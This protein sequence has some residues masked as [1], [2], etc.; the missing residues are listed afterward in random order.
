MFDKIFSCQVF[1]KKLECK[2]FTD[3]HARQV[4][5]GTPVIK[6]RLQIMVKSLIGNITLVDDFHQL[7]VR[8]KAEIGVFTR[9]SCGLAMSYFF[10]GNKWKTESTHA[11]GQQY[12]QRFQNLFLSGMQLRI[13][14]LL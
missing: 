13:N 4:F 2:V 10:R 9:N 7:C 12:M 3:K 6:A 14:P 11:V 5:S 1:E 8:Y